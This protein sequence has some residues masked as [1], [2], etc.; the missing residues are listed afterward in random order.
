MGYFTSEGEVK[1]SRPKGSK[2]KPYIEVVISAEVP[3]ESED[4]FEVASSTSKDGM[5]IN[6]DWRIKSDDLNVILMR[7]RGKTHRLSN[8][9]KP[10]SWELF[11]YATVAGALSSLVEKDIHS[12]GLKDLQT[13]V[14]RIDK[15]SEDIYKA[16]DKLSKVPDVV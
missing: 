2:N 7:R 10:D 9:N 4:K 5:T 15:I 16:L 12:T 6:A 11:Y 14:E 8:P 13:V 1:M 3:Q